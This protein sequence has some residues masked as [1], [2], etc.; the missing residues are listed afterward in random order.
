M[1]KNG[2]ANKY[3]GIQTEIHRLYKTETT[4]CVPGIK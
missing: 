1:T 2:I 3:P 4:I